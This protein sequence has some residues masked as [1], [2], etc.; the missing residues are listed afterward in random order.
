[1]VSPKRRYLPKNEHETTGCE[2]VSVPYKPWYLCTKVHG[3]TFHKIIT[4]IFTAVRNQIPI[5]QASVVFDA[6]LL[7]QNV[8]TTHNKHKLFPLARK[9]LR[10]ED[11]INLLKIL[12]DFDEEGH[13]THKLFTRGFAAAT[14]IAWS[15]VLF[16]RAQP[17]APHPQC[18]PAPQLNR[19]TFL[20]FHLSYP[21]PSLFS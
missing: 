17:R 9:Q 20:T 2:R 21:N 10:S 12:W 6:N 7:N 4:F 3:V 5:N 1:M 15:P 16:L 13:S 11:Q 14:S 19:K 8:N 18:S